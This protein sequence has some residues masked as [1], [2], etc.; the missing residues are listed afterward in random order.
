M[1]GPLKSLPTRESTLLE[2]NIFLFF[3]F[4]L[5]QALDPTGP[6]GLGPVHGGPKERP[7]DDERHHRSG[8]AVIWLLLTL[9]LNFANLESFL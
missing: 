2:F 6:L 8:N 3:Y 7:A 9:T 1:S 5:V 4:Y